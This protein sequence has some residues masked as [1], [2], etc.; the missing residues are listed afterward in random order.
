CQRSLL[1]PATRMSVLNVWQSG[2]EDTRDVRTSTDDGLELN[3]WWFTSAD[4]SVIS[5]ERR[6]ILYLPGNGG[7]RLDRAAICRRLAM[8]PVCDVVIFDYRGYG[9]NPG[10]PTES[11]LHKDAL[12]SWKYLRQQGWQPGQIIL[13]GESL[14]GAVATHLAS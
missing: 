7:C 11:G 14:G 8:L 3:G 13:F 10:S 6:V 12:A 4:E 2:T 1:Y 9:D 5:G